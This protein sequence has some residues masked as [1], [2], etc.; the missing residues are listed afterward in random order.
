VVRLLSNKELE[1]YSRQIVLEDIGTKGQKALKKSRV[2]V[3]GLGGLGWLTSLQLTGM[4]IGYI[5]V[6]DRDIV[7][8]SNL[9]RQ[10]I[11]SI[12][13]IGKPK[14]EV[15]AEKLKQRNSEIEVEPLTLSITLKNIN[16]IL[17]DIDVVVDC[18]DNFRARS[19][20][21]YGCVRNNIPYVYS[22]GIQL[23]GSVHTI[24]P[25]KSACM[26]C[27]YYNM[28]EIEA[29]SCVQ[30]G[31]LPTVLGVISSIASQEVLNLLLKREPLLAD[32][33][34]II[35][36]K[37]LNFD[38]IKIIRNINCRICGTN[39]VNLVADE[40]LIIESV[41]RDKGAF[42]VSPAKGLKLDLIEIY[43]QIENNYLIKRRG[44]MFLQ[45]QYKPEILIT[46]LNSGSMLIEG[47]DNPET[48]KRI[49]LE[50]LNHFKVE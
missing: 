45:I 1:R 22:A 11:Y 33:I 2:C 47:V 42:S 29:E 14:A 41:C 35:D 13:D 25:F 17:K 18:L 28:S 50:I 24:I 31:V 40:E 37:K 16:D 10:L 34:L 26:E 44:P 38:K 23:F 3:I 9:Q 36:L 12:N 21:N 6:V 46:L 7:E 49:F 8:L 15:V 43:R 20:I 30:V 39:P 5:R 32:D 4:G 27:V 48:A 19:I